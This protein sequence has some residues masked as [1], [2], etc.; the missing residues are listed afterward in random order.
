MS[1]KAMTWAFSQ[2]LA[3]NEKVVLLALADAADDIG[4]C[5]PSVPNIAAKAYVSERTVQRVMR[6]LIDGGYV[7]TVARSHEN[8]RSAANKYLLQMSE[9]D[10]LTPYEM[11]DAG[12]G[13]NLSEG[14][15]C[16]TV[17]GDNCV[18]PL[19]GTQTGTVTVEHKTRARRGIPLPD[20]FA[21]NPSNQALAANL[22]FSWPEVLDQIERMRNWSINAGAKGLK[23]DWQ[24]AFNNWL[25]EAAERRK[26]KPNGLDRNRNS[27]AGGFDLIDRA[28]EQ[29]EREIAAAESRQGRGQGDPLAL[30]GLRQVA[31]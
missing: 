23:N 18:T 16:V 15:N 24:R 22:N 6:D 4:I 7:S 26:G 21:P 1:L 8:G 31:S 19:K 29:R 28:I 9:G 20:D 10:N 3:G 17:E 2:P 27:I 13:D 14:D 5:W 30:P 25:R 11:A 12:E